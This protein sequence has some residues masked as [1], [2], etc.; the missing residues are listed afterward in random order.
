MV[1]LDNLTSFRGFAALYVV[2]GH[3]Q[4]IFP[5]LAVGIGAVPQMY[6]PIKL[7]TNAGASG[8]DFFFVLSALLFT[9]Q[10]YDNKMDIITFYIKRIF[11]TWILFFIVISIY[12]LIGWYVFSP[13]LYLRNIAA[14]FNPSLYDGSPFWTLYIEEMFYGIFPIW[15]WL[16]KRSNKAVF[17]G[18]TIAMSLAVGLLYD[19]FSLIQN[20]AF[21]EQLPRVL[22]DF[23]FGSVAGWALIEKKRI[24]T[25]FRTVGLVSFIA[26]TIVLVIFPALEDV[27]FGAAYSLIILGFIEW[28][29]T[30]SKVFQFFGN[31]SYG[32]YIWQIPLIF[33]AL[34]MGFVSFA[35]AIY[36][37]CALLGVATLSYYLIERPSLKLRDLIIARIQHRPPP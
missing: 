10:Y 34:N 32:L 30:K 18:V 11:R 15:L 23:A 27:A 13:W 8:V 5:V 12:G 6:W 19:N 21:F 28:S 1:R 31:I 4:S 3:M 7:V 29:P 25:W 33:F 22:C 14:I 16:F 20:P 37:F 24:P 9:W 26:A 2:V 35:A 17:T 36:G